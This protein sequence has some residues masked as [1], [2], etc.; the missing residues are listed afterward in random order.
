MYQKT[1]IIGRLGGDPVKRMTPQGKA[2]TS[3]NVATGRSWTDASGER[4]ENTVWFKVSAWEK[5]AE[6]CE[7]YLAKGKLV[8]VEGELSE[9]KPWQGNDGSWKASLELVARNVT[10]LSPNDGAR[11]DDDDEPRRTTRPL[12]DVDDSELIPF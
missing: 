3:F 1:T 6:N 2:V 11:R 8:F 5:L 4:H 7:K 9:P 12:V 10:F